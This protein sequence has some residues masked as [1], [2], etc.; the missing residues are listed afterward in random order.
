MRVQS[1]REITSWPR[2]RWPSFSPR[3]L[4]CRC[5]R[6]CSGAYWHDPIFL[7]GLQQMRNALGPL[8]LTSGHRCGLHNAAVG[9]APLSMHKSIAADI[10]LSGHDRFAVRGAAIA[11]GFTGLGYA[12]GFLHVDRRKQP[13]QWFYGPNSR[14]VWTAQ[15]AQI[16]A[17]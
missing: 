15:S 5:G 14:A 10:S 6:Y 1:W 7:D 13:A 12:S 17:I 16:E 9:G 11:A 2:D 4:A 8:H 3:E